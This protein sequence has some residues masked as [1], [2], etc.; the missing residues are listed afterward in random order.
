[1]AHETRLESRLTRWVA[2]A[3]TPRGAA[4]V[5]ATVS[6]SL[7]IIAG[8]LMTVSDRDQF[9]TLGS[10]LWWAVQTVTTVGYGDHVPESPLGQ[11]TASVVMLLGISFI[12][13]VT[14]SITSAFVT[15]LRR[16]SDSDTAGAIAR[17]NEINERL[18]RIEAALDGR[19]SRT[20]PPA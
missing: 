7:T 11:I 8:L 20:T 12:T 9:P 5:I 14:A 19:S 15:H 16:E 3:S 1:M 4:V 18:D 6:T 17:L 13:V 10:G 2:R